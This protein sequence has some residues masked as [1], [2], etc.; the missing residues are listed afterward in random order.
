[1]KKGISVFRE[2]QFAFLTCINFW[3]L[4]ELH[5]IEADISFFV[6]FWLSAKVPTTN[7]VRTSSG[8]SN[9]RRVTR[10]GEFSLM[11]RLFILISFSEKKKH[12]L[13]CF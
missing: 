2:K 10:L 8:K 6:L 11:G 12:V 1:M 13:R 9:V 5:R 3:L 4:A 7:Q